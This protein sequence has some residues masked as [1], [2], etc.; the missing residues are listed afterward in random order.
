M[1]VSIEDAYEIGKNTGTSIAC[2]NSTEIRDRLN[3]QKSEDDIVSRMMGIEMDYRD[4][5]P[6][7]TTS[8]NFNE[9]ENPKEVWE[10][11]ERGLKDSLTISVVKIKSALNIGTR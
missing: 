2:F 10:A 9:S 4:I 11:Y 3:R 6:F 1:N 5:P 8:K 7:K